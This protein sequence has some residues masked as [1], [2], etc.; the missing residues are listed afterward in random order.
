MQKI[1]IPAE[2]ATNLMILHS[3][4]L[5]KVTHTLFIVSLFSTQFVT[6]LSLGKFLPA[7]QASSHR[8]VLP[9][10]EDEG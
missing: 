9:S 7:N 10:W 2:M 5:V 6:S 8:T 4:I 1:K 3:Y